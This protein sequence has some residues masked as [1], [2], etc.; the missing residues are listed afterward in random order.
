MSRV[1]I[2]SLE[3]TSVTELLLRRA[4]QPARERDGE[5]EASAVVPRKREETASR[6]HV[7]L[8][9]TVPPSDPLVREIERRRSGFGGD[10]DDD[11]D[12]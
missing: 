4:K 9:Q 7:F 3:D 1:R 8:H 5:A 2:F 6:R 11:D 10:V 12:A